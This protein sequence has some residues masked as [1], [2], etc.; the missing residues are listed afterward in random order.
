MD[1][2]HLRSAQTTAEIIGAEFPHAATL[3]AHAQQGIHVEAIQHE[4]RCTQLQLQETEAA[5]AALKQELAEAKKA[6][7]AGQREVAHQAAI[8]AA[9]QTSAER[10]QQEASDARVALAA[11]HTELDTLKV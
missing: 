1:T 4:L 5:S 10:F 11:S 3:D 9:A 8:A 2:C 6:T 7:V